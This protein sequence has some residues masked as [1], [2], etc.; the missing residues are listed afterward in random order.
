MIDEQKIIYMET[1]GWG[2]ISNYSSITEF[3]TPYTFLNF[4]IIPVNFS[5]SADWRDSSGDF[6]YV[7]STFVLKDSISG[8]RGRYMCLGEDLSANRIL[9]TYVDGTEFI[10][11]DDSLDIRLE[12]NFKI[13]TRIPEW[14]TGEDAKKRWMPI[15]SDIDL[16]LSTE[17]KPE[18]GFAP[19][20]GFTISCVHDLKYGY[21]TKDDVIY[22]RVETMLSQDPVNNY[23]T[24]EDTDGFELEFQTS[25]NTSRTDVNITIPSI[26]TIRIQTTDTLVEDEYIEIPWINL[27][28][29]NFV[30]RELLVP[31]YTVERALN[32]SLKLNHPVGSVIFKRLPTF[33]GSNCIVYETFNQSF[34]KFSP[35]YYGLIEN[36]AFTQNVTGFDIELSS[37]LFTPRI[38]SLQTRTPSS[39]SRITKSKGTRVTL[40]AEI[41]AFPNMP[42]ELQ[43]TQAG[44]FYG[45]FQAIQNIAEDTYSWIKIGEIALKVV[46]TYIP[47][48]DNQTDVVSSDVRVY[49]GLSDSTQR[50]YVLN[51]RLTGR[52]YV[53]YF[54]LP[55][56]LNQVTGQTDSERFVYSNPNTDFLNANMIQLNNLGQENDN[57]EKGFYASRIADLSKSDKIPAAAKY[58]IDSPDVSL[59]HVFSK[60]GSALS[61][62]DE[63][64]GF[65]YAGEDGTE[66][67]RAYWERVH[68]VDIILQLLTSTGGDGE[69][70][71]FDVLPSEISFGIN[72]ERLD[73]ESFYDICKS[74][75]SLTVSN[76]YIEVEKQ[77][78]ATFLDTFL[79]DNFLALGQ[80]YDGRLKLIDLTALEVDPAN[81]AIDYTDYIAAIEGSIGF[82]IGLEYEAINIANTIGYTWNE[83]WS[84][85]TSRR[86][87]I[88]VQVNPD[89][90]YRPDGNIQA[91]ITNI[92]DRLKARPI[93]FDFNYAP[94]GNTIPFITDQYPVNPAPP[95]INRGGKYLS[96]YK[97]PVPIIT[98][99]IALTDELPVLEVGN[100]FR[101]SGI[102]L[103]GVDGSVLG[104]TE[105][106][107]CFTVD[108]QYDYLRKVAVYKAYILSFINP[109]TVSRWHIAGKI[110]NILFSS[111][112]YELTID[113]NF[114]VSTNNSDYPGGDA[115][116][117]V[118]DIQQF[119]VGDILVLCDENWTE[120]TSFVVDS[121][122][123]NTNLIISDEPGLSAAIVGDVIMANTISSINTIYEESLI[124]VNYLRINR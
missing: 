24:A 64:L 98:I 9:L 78:P 22:P 108:A 83:P 30:S 29:V 92:Y 121:K 7:G 80:G 65:P 19:T 62:A 111:P 63:I 42:T 91:G 100:L 81:P 116:N 8:V 26:N 88:Q 28:P 41:A 94:T 104:S 53:C 32:N 67:A 71:L 103:V 97:K 39:V 60:A 68:V 77:D 107:T 115:G 25:L 59:I 45:R 16:T 17:I 89:A 37:N 48:E 74:N 72:Q 27:E 5:G 21:Y 66:D 73:L 38:S 43:N 112:D 51:Q 118:K 49:Y 99:A 95:L 56:L 4:N 82:E 119:S 87:N 6:A 34:I 117:F 40:P 102:E 57:K 31:D 76:A 1:E 109:P 96:L 106:I 93:N 101:L 123:N 50:S 70:G 12:D 75:R 110:N 120:K 18:G 69:N 58:L 3:E 36:I 90:S 20:S 52:T 13:C 122:D 46:K 54:A 86:R 14:V 33:Q 44:E 84:D 23:Q 124:G 85:P 113:T 114:G 15:I 35:I 11:V 2:V 105:F 79:Q 55:Y 10:T 47:F 61:P